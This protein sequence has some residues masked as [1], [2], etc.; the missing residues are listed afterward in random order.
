M[1]SVHIYTVSPILVIPSTTH[2][3]LHRAPSLRSTFPRHLPTVR[4]ASSSSSTFHP[5]MCVCVCVRACFSFFP[6]HFE[7]GIRGRNRKR[8]GRVSNRYSAA[9]SHTSEPPRCHRGTRA[10]HNETTDGRTGR[11]R[12]VRY[13]ARGTLNRGNA[14]ALR[15]CSSPLLPP[16]PGSVPHRVVVQIDCARTPANCYPA[17]LRPG[18]TLASTTRSHTQIFAR[19]L[20]TQLSDS[21]RCCF[22]RPPSFLFFFFL[23][24]LLMRGAL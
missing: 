2:T 9:T 20:S 16:P 3:L 15:I 18:K 7:S 8:H 21:A 22:P 17:L 23:F 6:H 5:R 12:G 10:R 14:R 19:T 24:F 13:A 4:G 1:S 11:G